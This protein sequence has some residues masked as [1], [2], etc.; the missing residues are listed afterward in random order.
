MNKKHS[1]AGPVAPAGCHRCASLA[2]VYDRGSL[3]TITGGTKQL[4]ILSARDA[5][6]GH[7]GDMIEHKLFDRATAGTFETIAPPDGDEEHLILGGSP[8]AFLTRVLP[9]LLTDGLQ[10]APRGDLAQCRVDELIGLLGWKPAP[11]GVGG[12][13]PPVYGCDRWCHYGSLQ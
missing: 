5:A 8:A 1:R 9:T 10:L 2:I 3:L 12:K 4:E 13:P 11:S 7:R 6:E